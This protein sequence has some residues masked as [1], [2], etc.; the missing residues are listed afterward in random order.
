MNDCDLDLQLKLIKSLH[1]EKPLHFC[2]SAPH[3]EFFC[4][5]ITTFPYNLKLTKMARLLHE[6]LT[7]AR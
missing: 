1:N 4:V 7:P 5:E 2:T 6:T 3:F